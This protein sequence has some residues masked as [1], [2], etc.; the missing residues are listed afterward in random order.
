MGLAWAALIVPGHLRLE[1]RREWEAELWQLCRAGGSPLE[2]V[3]FVAGAWLDAIWE[4]KEGWR[5][6]L[7]M[8]DLRFA[9]RTLARSPG[10]TLAA[11]L[12][13]AL[14][15][16][17][18]TALF[19]VAEEAAFS[20]PPYPEPDRLVVVDMLFGSPEGD[21]D[22]NASIWSYPRYLALRDDVRSIAS[23][24]G[25][26]GR[27]MTLTELG[28][29]EVISVEVATPSLFP[30]LGVTA[31]RGRLFGPEEEYAGGPDMVAVVSA[32]FWET[33]MGRASDAV[34]S[35]ITLDRLR[36]RI[37]GIMEEGYT[38]VS[39]E[40][41]IWI[42]MSALWEVVEPSM[43]EDAWNQHFFVLGRLAEGV[44]REQADEEVAAFGST[45]M[46]R[47]PPPVGAQR[48]T[49]GAR[50]VG[51]DEAR[52]N[53][54]AARSVWALLAAVILVL[55]I[56]TA[57][58]AGLLL[59]RGA[60]RQREAAVR[61]SLGAGRA[62][63]V[64]QMLTESLTL[65]AL[66]GALGLA[67]ASVGIDLLG[68]WLAE[69]LGTG[70]ARGLQSLDTSALALDWKVFFFALMLTGGVGL[71]FG[72]LPAWQAARTDPTLWLRGGQAAIGSRR[73]LLG[74]NSRNVLMVGQ[75]ALA[76]VLLSGA[77]LMMRTTLALQAVDLGYDDTNLLTAMYALTPADEQ[78][79]IDPGTFHVDVVERLRAVPG[80]LGAS[81]GEVPMG[82]PTWRIIVFGSEGRPELT[83]AEHVWIR[84]QP[85]SDG[86][87]RMLGA[88]FVA[89]RDL[90]STDDWNT[91]K[92]V[93]LG[94]T[95]AEELFPDSDP[96]GQRIQLSWSGYGDPGATVVGVVED[97]QLGEPN[98]PIERQAFVP[99]RQAPQLE[100]GVL[101]RTSGDPE[102]MIPALRAAMAELAPELAV[103]SVMSMEARAASTTVRSRVL[104][105]LLG[106]FGSAALFLVAVGLYG[107][108]AYAV[109][110]RT[111]EL[112][113][114]ASLGAG[115]A[116]LAG[117]VLRQ[118]L[119][120]TLAGILVG[121]AGST[122]A[123]RFLEGLLFGTQ[124]LD[125]VGMGGA[126][127]L[128][129]SVAF[130]AAYL[131][132]RR[133]TRIDPMEALRSE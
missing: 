46:E 115:R 19:S 79:G 42:P 20:E 103:T 83:P 38:G 5:M 121:L 59:A 133:G 33:R 118:G 95:A 34:G 100:T 35:V 52:T 64:R 85:V 126:S 60:N 132:A 18:S 2:L 130:L 10:F 48:L 57:N 128:L 82:G 51:F 116:S 53:P 106:F 68:A 8:H 112:G 36:F 45:V 89:G 98:A 125:A 43:L 23:Y 55:L 96:I 90:E 9:V 101:V 113:L 54:M 119:G 27:T 108:I 99:V 50:V 47:F 127:L 65:A 88:D 61:A 70:S 117:L 84:I 97:L 80:V 1:R 26:E 81:V 92:V 74:M 32:S 69:A 37:L 104:T 78:A 28:D 122:W 86:H 31:Q 3:S 109:T 62:R 120:V 21:G 58:L 124:R 75:V 13:L 111:R 87:L 66:G 129:F 15:I 40:A 114:R 24:A 72:L 44:T 49:S 30:M 107:T 6:E 77:S 12:T 16:G 7:L 29:P 41:E 91:E 11:V 67:F 56:A 4:R 25:Y 14:S 76:M 71:A 22:M 131:P 73:R 102:A 39:G 94:R 17:A 123:S 63:L 93:V 105:M 110:R